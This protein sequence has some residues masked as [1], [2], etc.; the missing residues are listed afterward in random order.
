MAWYHQSVRSDSFDSEAT[1]ESLL[2][3]L[4][5]DGK[6]RKVLI[7]AHKNG[8]LYVLDRT[9]GKLIAANPYVRVNWATHIDLKSGRP[10]LTDLLERAMKGETVIVFPSRGTNATLIAFNPK[11]GLVYVNSWN[12][13]RLM[14]YVDFKFVL[15]TGSTGI[16]STMTTPK[17]EPA[18]YH[19]A[20]EPLTGKVAWQVPVV[21]FAGSAGLHATRGGVLVPRPF[22]CRGPSLQ[23]GRRTT[24]WA[25]KT[26]S[27]VQQPAPPPSPP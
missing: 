25:G 22:D 21:D 19:M 23:S 10:V 13:P 15:G 1:A 3:D 9:N 7:S 26:R 8:F 2:A 11:T 20:I 24:A 4:R 12:F 18:G 17:G 14:K 27:S 6:P 5:V 16:E